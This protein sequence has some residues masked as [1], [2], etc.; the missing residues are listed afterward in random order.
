[1]GRIERAEGNS[2]FIGRPTLSSSLDFLEDLLSYQPKSIHGLVLGPWHLCSRG[3]PFLGSVGEGASIFVKN[4][5][6]K[7]GGYPR[8]R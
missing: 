2:N 4:L 6:P 7:E 3:L 5:C 1:M 8:V